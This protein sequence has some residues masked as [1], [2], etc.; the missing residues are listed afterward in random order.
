MINAERSATADGQRHVKLPPR[1]G[2]DDDAD[3]LN[4]YL[5][6][7]EECQLYRGRP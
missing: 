2:Y 1:P 5:K 6:R 7:S 3:R 4:V